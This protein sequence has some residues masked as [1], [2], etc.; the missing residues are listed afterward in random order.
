M[1]RRATMVKRVQSL[2][3]RH[4]SLPLALLAVVS[5]IS[6]AAR[7][8]WL[9][10]PCRSPCRSVGDHVLVFD[11]AYYVNAARV[12]LGINP[13]LGAHYAGDPH[14]VDPNSE[15]PQLAKLI[16]AGSIELFGD[17]PLAWRLGSVVF[18]SLALLALFVLVRSAGGGRWLA[19]GACALMACDNLLLVHGRIGTLDIYVVTAMI[20]AAALYVR[21]RFLLA[22]A[23]V[24]VG[25]CFKLVAPYVLLVFGVLELMRWVS[26]EAE[27]KA[28]V[29]RFG[30]SVIA[31]AGVFVGLLAVLDRIARPYDATAGK[32]IARGPFAHLSHMISFASNQTSPR[33][34]QGIASYPWQWIV[35]YNPI[36]YLRINPARPANGLGGIHPAVHFFGVVSPPILALAVPALGLAA[37]GLRR[38][39][40]GAE[41]GP[42]VLGL[43]WV[44]GTF[45]PFVLL[46]LIWSRT[47]YLYYMVIVMPGIYIAIAA[48]MS[49]LRTRW[50]V[51]AIW[52]FTVVVAAVALYP[53][54]PWP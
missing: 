7:V 6:L 42:A 24:G 8:A 10:Q 48:L 17:G 33:G 54:T 5:L 43:A 46:S 4:P 50:W 2:V 30:A 25:A 49:R 19:L 37:Y 35:D 31:A 44:I 38:S 28:R 23:L 29:W 36:T 45:V 1:Y 9:G 21:G 13:P 53:F 22:G 12:I 51:I 14:G 3:E 15:H 16:I 41:T 34:P 18:G 26:G 39:R 11:E 32:L 52:G 20:W 27:L 40:A 47:S